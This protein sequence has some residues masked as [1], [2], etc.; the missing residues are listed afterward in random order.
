MQISLCEHHDSKIR[1]ICVGGRHMSCF[2]RKKKT[3]GFTKMSGQGN[4][5][6]VISNM[7][8]TGNTYWPDLA[9]LWCRSDEAIGAD[10]LLVL[11]QSLVA[12]FKMRIFNSDGSEAKMC[13]NGARCAARFACEQGIAPPHMTMETMAG[14]IESFV[15]DGSVSVKLTDAKVPGE[16]LSVNVDG[17]SYLLY[18]IDSGVPHAV[19]FR[20]CV[21][22]MSTDDIVNLGRLIR[23]HPAFKPAGTNVDFVE[24]VG[25]R[26]IRVRTY[27]RGVESETKACG[28]GAAA[29]AI[30]SHLR[31]HVGPPPIAVQMPGGIL[32]VDFRKNGSLVKDIWL[33][34]EV[35]SIYSGLL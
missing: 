28:T 18:S 13:G 17:R 14:T 9:A 27:E 20:D 4:T 24:V 26:V 29:A 12:D 33:S 23:F 6:I 30:I 25:P 5:F 19:T 21:V 15:A 10:G 3:V 8:G 16:S 34:G 7:F 1:K 2:E 35:K 32:T 31:T 11:E 22:E